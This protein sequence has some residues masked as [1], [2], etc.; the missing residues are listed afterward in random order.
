LTALPVDGL[1]QL[2]PYARARAQGEFS[3]TGV[4][5]VNPVKRR[6]LHRDHRGRRRTR[7]GRGRRRQKEDEAMTNEELIEM[8][9]DELIEE[10]AVAAELPDA[11]WIEIGLRLGVSG[12]NGIR[13]E[14]V[15]DAGTGSQAARL[16]RYMA[17]WAGQPE[18]ARR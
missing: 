16:R 8:T 12:L 5:R 18:E 4:E 6:V 1:S 9:N 10:L 13:P 7:T 15:E 3:G 17:L 11:V 2:L 14:A